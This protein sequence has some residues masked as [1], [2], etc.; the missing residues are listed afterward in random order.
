VLVEARRGRD[1]VGHHGEVSRG[2]QLLR[3]TARR[4]PKNLRKCTSSGSP[5]VSK[6]V[7][8]DYTYNEMSAAE[9]KDRFTEVVL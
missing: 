6:P 5:P 4:I 7:P 9:I 2:V 1:T 3:P 8:F